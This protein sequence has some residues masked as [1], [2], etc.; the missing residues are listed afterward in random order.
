MMA[1][2][3]EASEVKTLEDVQ[4]GDWIRIRKLHQNIEFAQVARVTPCQVTVGGYAFWKKNGR[5][6][7]SLYG[8]LKY[9]ARVATPEEIKKHEETKERERLVLDLIDFLQLDGPKLSM[10]TLKEW[11]DIA[12]KVVNKAYKKELD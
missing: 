7:Q 5:S 3:P 4:V 2:Q 8:N 10:E 12:T 6:I 9:H 1:N 11:T